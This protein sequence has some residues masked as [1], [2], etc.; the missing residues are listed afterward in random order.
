MP[1]L[2]V[3]HYLVLLGFFLWKGIFDPGHYLVTGTP[4]FANDQ[5]T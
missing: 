2:A 5:G 3:M 4:L 1:I